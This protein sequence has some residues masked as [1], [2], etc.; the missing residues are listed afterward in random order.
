MAVINKYEP[1]PQTHFLSKIP[2]V[3]RMRKPRFSAGLCIRWLIDKD[4]LAD[5]LFNLWVPGSGIF[6]LGV[7]I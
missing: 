1:L 6:V 7:L 3:L 4:A 2:V 5:P